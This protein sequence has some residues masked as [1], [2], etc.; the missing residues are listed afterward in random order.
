MNNAFRFK[1]FNTNNMTADGGCWEDIP[2]LAAFPGSHSFVH[3]TYMIVVDGM[4]YAKTRDEHSQNVLYR[5][6]QVDNF[7]EKLCEIN[8]IENVYLT[9]LDPFIYSIDGKGDIQ[10]YSISENTWE[11]VHPIP[12]PFYY[13]VI[14]STFMGKILVYGEVFSTIDHAHTIYK[15][16][17]YDPVNNK[18]TEA[19]CDKFPLGFNSHVKVY[20]V[21]VEHNGSCYR[22]VFQRS[23]NLSYDPSKEG[24]GVPIVHK[25]KFNMDDDAISVDLGEEENQDLIPANLIGAFQVEDDVFVSCGS[26][27]IHRTGLKAW[28]DLWEDK[29]DLQLWEQLYN[30]MGSNVVLYSFD[31]QLL[32]RK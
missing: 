11:V 14:I 4:L 28:E 29:V 8:S 2:Q 27:F 18:W 3:C 1:Y 7:W 6:R 16:Q 32:Q 30:R 23:F 13:D 19:L 26:S 10:R 15:L 25:L 12:T 20:P 22:V 21:I 31:K 17:V 5:Y 9:Y 24:A